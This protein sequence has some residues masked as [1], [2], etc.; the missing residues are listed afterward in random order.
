[1]PPTP[2][3][4]RANSAASTITSDPGWPA[5]EELSRETG[6]LRGH[7][8]Q[9]NR[10][11][12][13]VWDV[14]RS[15]LHSPGST[16]SDDSEAMVDGR[17]QSRPRPFILSFLDRLSSTTANGNRP[18][19]VHSA[20]STAPT[21]GPAAFHGLGGSGGGTGGGVMH[22]P[23]GGKLS[24]M[25]ELLVRMGWMDAKQEPEDLR[26][27]I[28]Q[29]RSTVVAYSEALDASNVEKAALERRVRDYKMSQ[30]PREESFASKQNRST[31]GTERDGTNRRTIT[32]A[33]IRRRLSDVAARFWPGGA[34]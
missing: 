22:H 6:A 8:A 15:F 30:G 2:G 14:D 16:H 25:E 21:L 28:R 3:S 20:Q 17:P 19:S 4:S 10:D 29:L 34:G 1:M 24:S 31:L 27:E 23:S 11:T 9:P 18:P 13:D 12:N 32:G 7:L 5:A 33:S 26:D